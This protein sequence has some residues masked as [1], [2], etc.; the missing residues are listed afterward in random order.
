L[1]TWE[2]KKYHTHGE[3]EF[4]RSDFKSLGENVIFEKGVLVF[5]PETISI[6]S[7]VYVGHHTILKGY[8]KGEMIIGDHSWIGQECFFHSAGGIIVGKAVGVG[9]MV[10]ILTSFH[11]DTDPSIPLLYEPL[12]FKEVIIEDG[13]DI[14]IASI[15]LPGVII[16]EGAIVGAGS[17]VTKHVSPYSVVAGN[18]ARVLRLRK[19]GS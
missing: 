3:G 8:H 10:K 12:E 6:G 18:P 7:N 16:G 14:G 4:E 13:C 11:K 1:K 9:P 17:V 15:L 5:H 2:Y 19:E